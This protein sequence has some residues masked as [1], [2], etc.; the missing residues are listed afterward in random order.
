MNSTAKA[1]HLTPDKMDE[2]LVKQAL[3]VF[4]TRHWH[5]FTA[6]VTSSKFHNIFNFLPFYGDFAE[7]KS[8]GFGM[9]IHGPS[10]AIYRIKKAI[11]L[12]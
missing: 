7:N 5:S 11:S 10:I 8:G 1:W 2:L 12:E 4:Q 3:A 9:Y 6:E